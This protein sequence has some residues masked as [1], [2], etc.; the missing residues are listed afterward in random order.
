M[1]TSKTG[2]E[3]KSV[4]CGIE[5]P[6]RFKAHGQFPHREDTLTLLLTNGGGVR[7][8]RNARPH[9]RA[10]LFPSVLGAAVPRTSAQLY[11]QVIT[12][13]PPPVDGPLHPDPVQG[14][15]GQN[16]I[17]SWSSCRLARRRRSLRIWE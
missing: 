12:R 11:S 7:G 14:H 16:K 10:H 4:H 1:H 2:Q 6:Q 17:V 5:L 9:G 3:T 8:A 15:G 13:Q